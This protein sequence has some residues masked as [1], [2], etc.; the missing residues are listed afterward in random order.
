MFSCKLSKIFMALLLIAVSSATSAFEVSPMSATINADKGKKEMK[1]SIDNN[2]D[3]LT[4]IEITTAKRVIDDL[5]K[6]TLVDSEDFYIYPPQ[7]ILKPLEKRTIKVKWIGENKPHIEEAYR[8]IVEQLPIELEE[9]STSGITL[10]FK[11]ETAL[12]LDPGNTEAD[13]NIDH[14]SLQNEDLTI[15]INNTGT[16][17]Q[18]LNDHQLIITSIA[19][20]GSQR[21]TILTNDEIET[22]RTKNVLAK[23]KLEI[24]FALPATLLA[25]LSSITGIKLEPKK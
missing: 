19:K 15:V 8:I 4:A 5:G 3:E 13:I 16:K 2:S 17:H 24:A 11:Y 6:E 23:H 25:E 7:L 18:A 14:F 20:D 21:E 9:K 22:L 10:L 1:F 12:Y